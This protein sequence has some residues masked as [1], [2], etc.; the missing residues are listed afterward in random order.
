MAGVLKPSP[1][2]S[3]RSLART[4]KLALGTE[5]DPLR[6][7]HSADVCPWADDINLSA[8]L[9]NDS[10]GAPPTAPASWGLTPSAP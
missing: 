3:P 4:S 9:C 7:E 2:F 8:P 6:A 5:S 1:H 10:K